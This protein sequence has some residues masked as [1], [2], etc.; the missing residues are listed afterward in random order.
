MIKSLILKAKSEKQL[1]KKEI[2]DRR[3][4]KLM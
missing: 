1:E 4:K 3:Y 2:I